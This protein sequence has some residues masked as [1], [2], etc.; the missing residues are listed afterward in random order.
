MAGRKV[1]RILLIASM[2]LFSVSKGIAET[3][4]DTEGAKK[5]QLSS[6]RLSKEEVVLDSLQL[7]LSI[8]SMDIR[9]QETPK[10]R[11]IEL[12]EKLNPDFSLGISY[13]NR[14][15]NQS[16]LEN[17]FI[18]TK[19]GFDD[20]FLFSIDIT[21][22]VVILDQ[23]AL[24]FTYSSIPEQ[25]NFP[26]SS[27]LNF[28]TERIILNEVNRYS[29]HSLSFSTAYS[30]PIIEGVRAVGQVGIAS[31][32]LN[33]EETMQYHPDDPFAA[34]YSIVTLP[35]RKR[36][37]TYSNPFAGLS[38]EFQLRSVR[39]STG[40]QIQLYELEEVSSTNFYISIGVRIRDLL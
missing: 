17:N 22:S 35:F 31:M 28:E 10:S 12:F 25:R 2:M 32:K 11:M 20:Q 13:N 23:F 39:I 14:S 16:F 33:V 36:Q 27:I 24:E 8:W 40:Y 7:N 19:K 5:G 18:L 6:E 30:V 26:N 34:N 29:G 38:A 3:G 37:V 4:Q 15:V 9:L 1:Y 21:P